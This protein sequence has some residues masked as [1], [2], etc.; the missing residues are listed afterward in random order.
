GD[1]MSLAILPDLSAPAEDDLRLI[2]RLKD[3]FGKNLR[4]AV[5]PDYHGNDRF[6]I[7]QAAAMVEASGIPLMATNDVLYH[8]SERR[9]LQDVL[10]A[11]RLNVPIAEAGLE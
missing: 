6:R 8:T 9:R 1:L 4:L 10:T 11:I 2:S 5:S 7:E 3:R